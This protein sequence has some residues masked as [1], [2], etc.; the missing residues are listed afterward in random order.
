[1][2]KVYTR[3]CIEIR[4]LD[5]SAENPRVESS[6]KLICTSRLLSLKSTAIGDLRH[7]TM[8]VSFSIY[9]LLFKKGRLDS[10]F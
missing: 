10:V 9:E 8:K 5:W 2:R 4:K 6:L 7:L 1:M 3:F